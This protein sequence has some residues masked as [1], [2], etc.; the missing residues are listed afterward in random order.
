MIV[1][2]VSVEPDP[3]T[4]TVRSLIVGVPIT[5]VGG[6]FAGGVAA[7][8]TERVTVPV[9]PSSSVTVN[10]TVYVPSAVYVRDAV[11]PVAVV[12]SPKFHA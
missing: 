8:V 1:P 10:R 2:S 12:P 9:S 5:A 3:D 4:S 6:W 7:T 11:D